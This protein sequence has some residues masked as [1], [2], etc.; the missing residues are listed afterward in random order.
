MK[1]LVNTAPGQLVMQDWP[2]PEPG[3]RQVR[4]RTAACAICG[5]DITMIAGWKRTGFPAIP[6]HEWSGIVDA[7]GP[8]VTRD[9]VGCPCVAENVLA[10]GGEVGFEHPGGYAEYF[11][12][13]ADKLHLLPANFPLVTAALI[14]PLAVVVRGIHRLRLVDTSGALVFGDGAIGLLMVLL[15]RRAGVKHIVTVGGRQSRLSLARELGGADVLNYRELGPDPAPAILRAHGGLFPNVI[16]ASGSLAAMHMAL[17][18]AAACGRVLMLGDQK[19]GRADFPWDHIRQREIEVIG[20]N[21][22]AGAW[23][24]AMH[25]AV[26]EKL[27]LE[28]LISHRFPVAQYAEAIALVRSRSGDVVKA[29]LEW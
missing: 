22:S 7:V 3:P 21:A 15:L 13:E 1:A 9:L 14:E 4:I 17:E 23:P 8:D 16:E 24:L 12:T 11:L 2:L 18:L 10:D 20:S 26:E 25:L 29:V 28:R 6:G 27:P 19:E 5:T